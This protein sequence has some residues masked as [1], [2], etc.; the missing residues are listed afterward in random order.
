MPKFSEL[1]PSTQDIHEA[2]D[3]FTDCAERDHADD[4]PPEASEVENEE[5]R[6]SRESM[7]LRELWATAVLVPQPADR[8]DAD[9]TQE[10]DSAGEDTDREDEDRIQEYQ[11]QEA[12]RAVKSRKR[13]VARWLRGNVL[14][15]RTI[16]RELSESA[17][18][19]EM[20]LMI[21]EIYQATV[22][23]EFQPKILLALTDLE[24]P[25]RQLTVVQEY[26]QEMVGGTDY[27]H[28][29]K[30]AVDEKES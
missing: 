4:G 22:K 26:Y 7:E 12:I 18:E 14:Q 2:M 13:K 27:H 1:L 5:E 3:H 9:R 16:L 29:D 30:T 28:S 24:N 15:K 8:Q 20:N 19:Q 23:R 6:L 17:G 25:Q 21:K 10:D 11:A